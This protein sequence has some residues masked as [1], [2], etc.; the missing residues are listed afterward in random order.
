VKGLRFK[1]GALAYAGGA[2][3]PLTIEVEGGR[4]AGVEKAVYPSQSVSQ[5]EYLLVPGFVDVHVHLREPGFSYKE[6]IETG[7]MAAA[8]AGVTAL[9]TMPNVSPAP[10]GRAGLDAQLQLI[11]AGARVRVYPCGRITKNG[12][13]ADMEAIA[14][15][16]AGFSDDG[17]GVQDGEMMELA[18]RTARR[19]DRPI[20]AH[21]EDAACPVDSPQAEWR[22]LERDLLLAEKTGC[23]YHACHLSTARSVELM[24][25]AKA[26]GIDA[27]CETAPHYLVFCDEDVQDCGRFRMNPPIR[28]RADREALIQGLA[29]GVI[30]MIATDHAPHSPAE[31]ARGYA[32]SL[33]GIVGLETAFCALYTHLVLPGRVPLARLLY[34][35]CDAPRSRFRIPGGIA[36]GE[37]ADLALIDLS[38]ARV[39]DPSRFASMGRSTPFEGMTLRGEAVMTMVDGRIVYQ[40]EGFTW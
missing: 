3:Q 22:Q 40:K 2:L 24:R 8:R 36:P 14:P 20:I 37:R 15:D 26:R 10:D 35:M 5:D 1:R 9:I 34:A 13:L 12:A 39:V 30:D 17:M 16:V 29:D 23:R 27:T 7:T 25:A 19:L 31:K 28:S 38:A 11:R 21:C 33:N 6:T 4:I 32:G 18:M